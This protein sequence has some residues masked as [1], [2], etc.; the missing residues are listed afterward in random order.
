MLIARVLH[1]FLA[2]FL[3]AVAAHA[4][5]QAVEGRDYQVLKR[6]QATESGNKV[7]VLEFFW[8]GCPHCNTLQGPLQKWLKRKPADVEFRRVA[9]AFQESWVPLTRV[10]YTLDAMNLVDK[11]HHEVFAA[12]HEQKTRL[13]DQKVLLDWV[14]SKGVDRQKFS[15]TYNSFSV[16]SRTQRAMEVTR[17]YDIPGTPAIVIDGRYLTAPSMVVR[18][19]KT[20]DYDR[21]FRIVDEVI[22]MARKNKVAK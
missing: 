13:S 15:D 9:A 12:I 4:S 6:P 14:A 7:E 10:Y 2:I 21:Y 20:I 17:A 11:L 8:Y 5:A 1:A 3:L 19:D 22:A 16:Q 18:A